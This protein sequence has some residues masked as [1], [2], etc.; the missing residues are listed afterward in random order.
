MTKI[1]KVHFSFEC[2]KRLTAL[3]YPVPN[4]DIGYLVQEKYSLSPSS[5]G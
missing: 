5:G 3:A 1:I 4:H 2:T